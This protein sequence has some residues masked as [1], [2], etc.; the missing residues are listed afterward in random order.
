MYFLV[1]LVRNLLFDLGILKSKRFDIPI[2]SVGNITVGG[3]G[4]TP[5]IEYFIREFSQ[6]KRVAVLSAGYKRKSSGFIIADESSTAQ[7]VGD[8]PFQIFCKFEQI[9]V[10]VDRNRVQAIENLLALPCPPD[11]I[12]LDDAFQ[13]RKLTPSKQIVLV[14]Y[15]RPVFNDRILPCG[16]LRE[17]C[18]GLKRANSVIVT[19]CPNNLSQQERIFWK[20]QLKLPQ[21][22]DLQFS[23][24]DFFPLKNIFSHE[25]LNINKSYNFL[26]VTGVVSAKSLYEYLGKFAHKIEKLEFAD[27]HDFSEK[28]IKKIEQF[29]LNLPQSNSCIIVTEKDAARLIHNRYITDNIKK[30]IFSVEIKVRFL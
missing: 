6:D 8:E 10:A 3:T 22:I 16:R 26:V 5:H 14:D 28:D 2:I 7:T 21:N 20:E 13:Y 11:V 27:H 29:F 18:R 4:K 25:E 17:G 12:L 15:N 24:F 9:I 19:K 30:K 1:T 23:T